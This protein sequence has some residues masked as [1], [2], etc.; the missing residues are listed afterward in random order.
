M[1]PEK[2]FTEKKVSSSD[3]LECQPKLRFPGFSEAYHYKP[4]SNYLWENTDRNKNRNLNISK[5]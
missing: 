3:G 1:T 5:L 2:G 4:L